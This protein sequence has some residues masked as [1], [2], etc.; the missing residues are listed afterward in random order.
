MKRSELILMVLQV[1]IDFGLLLLAGLSAFVLR[2]SDWAVAL[3]PISFGL[4]VG[5]FMEIVLYVAFAWILIFSFAGL[6]STDPNRKLSRDLSRL[7]LAC[8]TGLAGVAMYVMFTQQLFDSRFLVASG[9]AFAI[10][11]V[12]IGRIA[13]RGVKGAMYR[14]GIGLRQ[15]VV[16]GSGDVAGALVFA[17][18]NHKSF[19]YRVVRVLPNF[20]SASTKTLDTLY[21]DELLFTNPRADQ[22]ETL[23]AVDYCNRYHKTF[24]Y[25]ADLFATLSTNMSV[26]PLAG[27]PIVELRRTRLGGWGRVFKRGFDIFFATLFFIITLP[28]VGICT[29][30]ILIETGKPIIYKNERVGIRGKRFFV[31]KLRSM[32]QKDSTGLQF[33]KAGKQ[34]EQREQQLIHEKDSRKGPIYKVADD[35]RVTPFGRFLRRWSLDELPQFWN[36][37]KG[38]MSLVGPRPHQPREVMQYQDE[39]PIVFTLKPGVTG[40]A[41]ISG[42]S[43]LS[44]EEEM[45]LDAL[46]TE[47]WTLLIDLI[48]LIKTPFILFKKRKAL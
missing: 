39:Y 36:V 35:P 8:S 18:N 16:I 24:K 19:G 4:S 21:F 28:V 38:D 29:I 32:Y 22:K 7:F 17:L 2:F 5:M 48:I 13:M 30:I 15:V 23:R 41:Q 40:L 10:V 27:V 46:Y 25:S 31:Y 12:G 9:W 20:T 34:A 11:Y 43:D 37:I 14:L 33:G 47:K 42:R 1:P 26:S 45:R 44:F 6:Y 3:K